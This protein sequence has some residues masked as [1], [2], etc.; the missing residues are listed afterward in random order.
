MDVR[1]LGPL[2]VLVDGHPVAAGGRQQRTVLAALVLDA[3]S[4][5]S[6]D[7]LVDAVWGAQPPAEAVNAVQGY[8][9]G[10]RR[11][12]GRER[13]VTTGAG[14]RLLL[15]AGELDA[16]QFTQLAAAGS[17][18]LAAGDAAG[19]ARL[20]SEALSLWRGAAL[21]EFSDAPF[22]E[23]AVSRL[24]QARLE[25][26][27]QRIEADLACGRHSAVIGE[28]EAL[29][30]AHPTRERL[31][32][33]LMLALYRCQRQAEA[34]AAYQVADRSLRD[35]LGIEPGP[36]LSALQA[37]ILAHDPA[38]D[39]SVMPAPHNLPA[40]VSELVGRARE[41]REVRQILQRPGIR[42]LTL[43]GAGGIGKTRLALAVAD[44]IRADYPGG[45][46]VVWLAAISDPADVTSAIAATLNVTGTPAE[47]LVKTLARTIGTSNMLLVLDNFEHVLPAAKAVADLLTGCPKLRILVTSRAVL[48]VSGENEYLVPP[49]QLPDVADAASLAELAES[50][51][52][53]LFVACASRVQRDFALTTSNTRSVAEICVRLDG[54]PLAIELAAART[55][56]LAPADLLTRLDH[57]LALLTGGPRD[58]PARQQTL[59]A[60]V[61][62]SYQLLGRGAQALFEQLAV[63]VGGATFSA[64]EA[65]C[66][67]DDERL[68]ALAELLD[69]SLLVSQD[70]GDLETRF[71]LLETVREYAI[72]LQ[73]GRSA[74]ADRVRQRHA[75]YYLTLAEAGERGLRTV[76]HAL[77]L[78]RFDAEQGNLREAFH[79]LL[80]Y[81]GDRGA[82]R[83][84]VALLPWWEARDITEGRRWLTASVRSEAATPERARALYSLGRLA[85]FQG[86]YHCALVSL[87]ESAALAEQLEEP[88]TRLLALGMLGWVLEEQGDH[89]ETPDLIARCMRILEA[90]TDRWIRAEA[91]RDIGTLLLHAKDVQR[92]VQFQRESLALRRQLGDQNIADSLNNLGSTLLFVGDYDQARENL[93]DGLA[94]ARR[95]NDAFRVSLILGN[96]GLVSLFQHRYAESV[97]ELTETARL[98]HLQGDR[99]VL[100]EALLGLSGAHSACCHPE[101]AARLAGAAE[102]AYA[103]IGGKP[104]PPIEAEVKRCLAAAHDAL[105]D[106]QYAALSAEGRAMST[107]AVVRYA[108][109]I[110]SA[111]GP[112]TSR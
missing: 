39:L 64:I 98:S 23:A 83:L 78:R 14:Y 20:L 72:E 9:S 28:L 105:G 11:V 30:A 88:V 84:A 2:D 32:A 34:L 19:A 80:E 17:A 6:V 59:R 97:D 18:S 82:P 92:A 68:D 70:G 51:A 10:L 4:V 94:I 95:L 100:S 54:L 60:T 48:H 90:V 66:S 31:H 53:A 102:A 112:L 12:L 49:L 40:P 52:V 7:R 62:W 106:A 43:T 71:M 87:R 57:R 3:G 50:E 86:D 22:A 69:K 101:D 89:S 110:R 47:P 61:E 15:R 56:L 107:D 79:T 65:I 109:A 67:D 103:E 33:Q 36:E 25:A 5:V 108:L 1:V 29:A 93:E 63:F 96:I 46:F 13:I 16:D 75:E 58:L 91:L 21:A 8:V 37:A 76:G 27:E 35:E 55:K 26:I 41:V 81:S 42:L 44:S 45:T 38:L 85:L 99:R 24:E 77:W 104:D 111:T 73:S 74:E